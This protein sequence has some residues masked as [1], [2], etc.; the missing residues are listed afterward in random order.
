[1]GYDTL[2]VNSQ[3]FVCTTKMPFSFR[4][5][6]EFLSKGNTSRMVSFTITR[7]LCREIKLV[8]L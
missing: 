4:R 8:S 3:Y 7:I 5:M 1:M 6:N 2:Y